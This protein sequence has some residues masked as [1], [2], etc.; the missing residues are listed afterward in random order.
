M[1]TARAPRKRASQPIRRK[2]HPRAGPKVPRAPEPMT[3]CG[4]CTGQKHIWCPD[5]CGFAGYDTCHFTHKVACPQCAGGTWE[6][7]RW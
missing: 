1:T 3:Y 5:C 7:I 2:H 4:T 6:P